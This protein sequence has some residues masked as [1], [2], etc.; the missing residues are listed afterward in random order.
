MAKFQALTVQWEAI[1]AF[2]VS[3]RR[4]KMRFMHPRGKREAKLPQLES[5][6]LGGAA[7]WLSLKVAGSEVTIVPHW[8]LVN[9]RWWALSFAPGRTDAMPKSA[10]GLCLGHGLLLNR[11]Y[12]Q[13]PKTQVVYLCKACTVPYRLF[14]Y[15][16]FPQLLS[17][18]MDAWRRLCSPLSFAVVHLGVTS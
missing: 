7:I 9:V 10:P 3:G 12:G 18:L 1:Q 11:I 14:T 13:H 16:G 2:L 8:I 4:A 15:P 17:Q 5:L 6:A